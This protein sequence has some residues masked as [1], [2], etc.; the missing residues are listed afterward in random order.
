MQLPTAQEAG[1]PGVEL[2]VLEF[3]SN[4]ASPDVVSAIV[5]A[6]EQGQ[7]SVLDLVFLARDGD[8]S[9]RIVDVDEELDEHGFGQLVIARSALLSGDDLDRI[10]SGLTPGTSAAVLVYELTW[11]L[12]VL[13]A[14]DAAGG[15]VALHAAEPDLVER[16]SELAD[17]RAS[18]RLT[19][20]EFTAAKAPLLR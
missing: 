8:G 5:D 7:I 2:M 19:E 9:V 16:L 15:Q 4:R 13:D 11:S 3:P 20:E 17:L 14:L 1:V 6:V 10:R 18:G 12:R